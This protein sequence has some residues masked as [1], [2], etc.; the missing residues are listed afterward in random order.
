MKTVQESEEAYKQKR[1]DQIKPTHNLK[2]I[3]VHRSTP[4]TLE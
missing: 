3:I 2:F 1:K 4:V